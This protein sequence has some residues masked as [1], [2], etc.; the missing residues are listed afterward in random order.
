MDHRSRAVLALALLGASAL[1]LG[2]CQ[3]IR[4][5][6]G[7]TKEGPDEFAIVTKQP[8]I[9]PP[10]YN[11]RPPRDGAPPT[12]QVAP[13]DSAQ[14]ALFDTDPANAA[15]AV[16]GDA[17]QAEKLLLAQA[18]ATNPDPSIR[19]LVTADGRAMEAAGD[20]FTKQ[21]LFWQDGK[22]PEG[23]PVDAEAEDKR[24]SSRKVAGQAPKAPK[25]S[26]T[27][28]EDD[29]DTNTDQPSSERSGFWSWLP[30]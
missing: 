9:I 17:S 12:N 24:L 29:S 16:P 15:K 20:D 7:M 6:A 1:S 2:G 10:E 13:T 26:A 28:Q 21:V 30:F 18:G 22:T 11:L 4:S 25:D 19:Q 3:T 5:A 8:L 27:I 14:A 23:T